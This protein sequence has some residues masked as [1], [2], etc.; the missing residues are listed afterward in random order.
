MTDTADASAPTTFAGEGP[1]LFR[2]ALKTSV[3]TL[4]TLGFYRFWAKTRLRRYYWAA[5]R[6]GGEPLEY[7]GQG[8]EKLLGF[9]IAVVFLAFYIGIVNLIFMFASLSIFE[10][11]GVGYA[12]SA[13]GLA[14]LWFY[15]IYRARRYVLA[16]TRWRG[17][18][19][20]LEPGAW[21]YAWRAM[22]HWAITICSA[23]LLW[24][25]MTFWLEKYKTDRTWFGDLKL[26]QGGS[27]TMLY[28]AAIPLLVAV[29]GTAF[30]I[31]RAAEGEMQLLFLLFFTIPLG[32]IGL[33]YYRV[34]S[35]ELLTNTKR[36][37]DVTLTARPR[38]AR[39][40]WIYIAGNVV[41]TLLL[42]LGGSL[43]LGL[44]AAVLPVDL[45]NFDMENPSLGVPFA[46][47]AGTLG[48]GYI[49][50]ILMWQTLTHVFITMPVW[51]H[52]AETLSINAAPG[53]D[54]VRQRARDA[55][56]EAEGFAEALDLGASI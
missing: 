55:H 12:V 47:V 14:P 4:V 43:I 24:P 18:R 40:L 13:I 5:T 49:A 16:R 37:G 45:A 44:M 36:A 7:V 22:V 53:L 17:I 27:W 6:P 42:G 9:L 52:Y 1:D 30:V 23:G 41:I 29:F 10:A 38:T 35:L 39:V 20:A 28:A 11:G 46:I 33:V 25:R 34:R 3:L 50:L 26:T 21:G 15:A 51:Q 19:F 32:L 31:W 2:L 54:A 56:R 8:L 48:L